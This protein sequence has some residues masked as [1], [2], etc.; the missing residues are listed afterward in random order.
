MSLAAETSLTRPFKEHP[1][2]V[3]ETYVEHAGVASRMGTVMIA[4]G[5]ACLLHAVFPF[6]FKRTG[7]KMIRWMS[8]TARKRR[9]G[10]A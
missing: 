6:L 7:S 5:F 1:D 2:A 9:P 4:A 3:G 10:R 8:L